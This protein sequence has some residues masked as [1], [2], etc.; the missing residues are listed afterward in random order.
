MLTSQFEALLKKSLPSV[1]IMSSADEVKEM[2]K[3]PQYGA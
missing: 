2:P 1:V 3:Q